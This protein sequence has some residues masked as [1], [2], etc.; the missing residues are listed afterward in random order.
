MP[1]GGQ[2]SAPRVLGPPLRYSSTWCWRSTIPGTWW[3]PFS[4]RR[5]AAVPP[6]R[7]GPSALLVVGKP[8]H[9]RGP[10]GAVTAGGW[11]TGGSHRGPCPDGRGAAAGA[12]VPCDLDGATVLTSGTPRSR[13][14]AGARGGADASGTTRRPCGSR[15][16]HCPAC[17]VV[18]TVRPVRELP[19]GC[20]PRSSARLDGHGR[21]SPS[22]ASARR[23]GRC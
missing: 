17:T 10:C 22:R 15:C 6:S 18:G 4:Q 19:R 5:S 14:A 3:F 21:R 13:H 20:A 16:D 1:S 8:A 7:A 12:A 11:P 9:R 2:S 23:Y